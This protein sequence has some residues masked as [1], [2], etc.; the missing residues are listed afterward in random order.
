ML[1]AIVTG[2]RPVAFPFKRF[3]PGDLSGIKF[4][5][6]QIVEVL[7]SL[8]L[9]YVELRGKFERL[10]GDYGRVRESNIRLSD[11]LQEVKLENKAMRQVSADYERVKR[12]FGPEQV[13]RILEAAYQQEHAEKERKRAAK[14][15]IR[16]DA[17]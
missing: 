2:I 3:I 9:A 8:Y 7:R 15:K 5:L 13:D 4:L 6:A 10:Q 14:S 16:I 17:R 12:A 1:S 11:R